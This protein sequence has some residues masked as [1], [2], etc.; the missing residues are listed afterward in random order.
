MLRVAPCEHELNSNLSINKN[1]NSNEGGGIEKEYGDE[2]IIDLRGS[3]SSRDFRRKKAPQTF[4]M[5]CR[6]DSLIAWTHLHIH[7]CCRPQIVRPSVVLRHELAA[8]A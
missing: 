5:G 2:V 3:P 4:S 8:N 7:R 1:L 6:D